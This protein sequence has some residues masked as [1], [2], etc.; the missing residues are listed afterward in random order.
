[1]YENRYAKWKY[2]FLITLIFVGALSFR[3]YQDIESHKENMNEDMHQLTRDLHN[4]I[5]QSFID[6]K[7]NYKSIKDIYLNDKDI[8]DAL[9][10]RDRKKLYNLVKKDYIDLKQINPSLF[11]MH[12][13]DKKN[14][15]ILRM[16]KPQSY[17]DDLSN[18]RPIVKKVNSEKTSYEAFEVGKN[19]VT[20]RITLALYS[21]INNEYLGIL[22]FGIKPDYFTKMI[23]KYNDLNSEILVNVNCLDILT[24]EHNYK[25][26]DGYAV[27]KKDPFIDTILSSDT[28]NIKDHK[29]FKTNDRYY[30][31]L[32]PFSFHDIK[33]D[34]VAKIIILKDITK[35]MHN[36]KQSLKY[37]NSINFLILLLG[38]ILTFIIFN[39]YDKEL[40]KNNELLQEYVESLKIS[41]KRHDMAQKMAHIGH[42]EINFRKKNIYLSKEL[43]N[44]LG[45]S[46]DTKPSVKKFLS[47]I[48]PEDTEIVKKSFKRSVNKSQEFEVVHR[49]ITQHG[50]L[51]HIAQNA[52]HT[53][54]SYSNLVKTEGTLQDITQIAVL[55]DQAYKD[56]LTGLLNR[57]IID[58]MMQKEFKHAIR[59]KTPFSVAIFD[60]DD[61]KK[62][63]DTY[64]HDVGDEVLVALSE[65]LQ[66]FFR[67]SDVI[68]RWG[69]EEFIVIMPNSNKTSSYERLDILRKEIEKLNI[70]SQN[71]NI[72]VSIG[73]S[74]F[75]NDR[76]IAGAEE[77]FKEA[78]SN[79]YKAKNSGK[80]RVIV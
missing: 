2:L 18:V 25:I 23:K 63:N 51:K 60:I 37:V 73:V 59:N 6:L 35:Y 11:V 69:G 61:F 75:E 5:R 32:T 72:T 48:H 65:S 44:I 15:T 16:H 34:P 38:V 3:I 12:W 71:L 67:D 77:L 47:L 55:K 1:M 29:V 50:D 58:H 70:G 64:G 68:G 39:R 66:S 78:D 46:H 31:Y 22:E 53:Y 62:V 9:K 41:K 52:H 76:Y 4:N 54:D 80:N 49:I 13:I 30:L 8:I 57:R 79:L 45:V 19:G 28:I 20:Y 33:N 7:N 24:Y 42:W 10:N 56:A 26:M 27:I 21:G 40:L 36:Y 14:R 43:Y 74:S 17:D